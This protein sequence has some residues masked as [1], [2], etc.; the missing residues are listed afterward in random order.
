VTKDAIGRHVDIVA[1][2]AVLSCYA[3]FVAAQNGTDR[4]HAFVLRNHAVLERMEHHR[5]IGPARI[6]PSRLAID[7]RKWLRRA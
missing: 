2:G 4:L 5:R 6:A 1:I 3:L 7:A